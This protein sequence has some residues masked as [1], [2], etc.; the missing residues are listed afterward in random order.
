MKKNQNKTMQ[1][2]DVAKIAQ[3][4]PNKEVQANKINL[5]ELQQSESKK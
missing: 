4:V 2:I 3:P 1:P 5:F